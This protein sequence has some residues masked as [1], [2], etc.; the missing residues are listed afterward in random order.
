MQKDNPFIIRIEI[1]SFEFTI[2]GGVE[3]P[4]LAPVYISSGFQPFFP[5]WCINHF[6]IENIALHSYSSAPIYGY[7]LT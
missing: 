2:E 4:V 5:G 6:S 7:A 3:S 1:F